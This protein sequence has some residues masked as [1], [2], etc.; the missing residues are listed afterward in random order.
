MLILQKHSEIPPDVADVL[1]SEAD[2]GFAHALE[3]MKLQFPRD[4]GAHPEYQIE[5]WYYT[6][7]LRTDD[8]KAFGLL[9]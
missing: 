6:G 2:E 3:P 4:H 1:S 5:W 9:S 8:G 7:N